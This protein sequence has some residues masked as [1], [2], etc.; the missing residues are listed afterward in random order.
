MF[1]DE[2]KIL[3]TEKRIQKIHKKKWGKHMQELINKNDNT[4][5]KKLFMK[6]YNVMTKKF[7]TRYNGINS[8]FFKMLSSNYNS[9]DPSSINV[10]KEIR[11][12]TIKEV[13]IFIKKMSYL[14]KLDVEIDNKYE[15]VFFLLTYT[16][17]ESARKDS[18]IAKLFNI[19]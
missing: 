15:N 4:K 17:S 8:V 12:L 7:K 6:E 2:F 14:H 19:K 5:L 9:E 16:W 1:D 11:E 13:F 10:K 18:E 3:K